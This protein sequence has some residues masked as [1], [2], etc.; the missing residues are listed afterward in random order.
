VHRELHAL[1]SGA[2]NL[3][4][5]KLTRTSTAIELQAKAGESAGLDNMLDVLESQFNQASDE[6]WRILE[7]VAAHETRQ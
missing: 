2:G 5:S 4:A 1:R 3:G 7:E 6:L